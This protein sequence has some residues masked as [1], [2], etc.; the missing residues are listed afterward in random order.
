M[1]IL[2]TTESCCDIPAAVCGQHGIQTVPFSVNFPDRSVYD[3]SIPAEEIFEFYERTHTIPK[4]NAVNPDQYTMFWDSILTGHPEAVILHVGY[5]SACSCSFQNA[6]IGRQDCMAPERVRLVDSL[7]VSAG[8]GNL[9]LKAAALL[10]EHPDDD[11]ETLAARV[12]AFVPKTQ[13]V[14]V[15]DRL[16]FLAAGGR[17]SNAAALGATILRLKPRIDI[18]RGELI[19][20]RKYR[21]T[22]PHVVPH[23]VSDFLKDRTFDL[24]QVYMIYAAGASE[25][26]LD[27]MR[28]LLREHGFRHIHEWDLGCVMTVHGGKAAV[29]LSAT[30]L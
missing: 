5:S 1:K 27:K 29:G 26:A 9:V 18:I 20:G 22:M 28:A 8:L 17:V 15:P 11:L 3:N 6:Q 12:E 4:T 16:D 10:A 24:S 7:N 30:E 13:M 2:I 23:L 14:F 25:P 21:G 19:A